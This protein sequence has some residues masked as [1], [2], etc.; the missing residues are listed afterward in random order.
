MLQMINARNKVFYIILFS[1][2]YA[3]FIIV[4]LVFMGRLNYYT[5][6]YTLEGDYIVDAEVSFGMNFLGGFINWSDL[7]THIPF[8]EDNI[9]LLSIVIYYAY[10]FSYVIILIGWILF[11]LS[12]AKKKKKLAISISF[13]I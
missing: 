4:G 9:L 5:I 11:S 3:V 8:F 10:V 6:L 13:F 7:N 1:F 2:F 12:S